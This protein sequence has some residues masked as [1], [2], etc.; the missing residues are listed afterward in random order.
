[1]RWLTFFAA[2]AFVAASLGAAPAYDFRIFPTNSFVQCVVDGKALESFPPVARLKESLDVQ[3]RKGLSGS[4]LAASSLRDSI[5][6]YALAFMPLDMVP[7]PKPKADGDDDDGDFEAV[8]FLGFSTNA[9]IK[10]LGEAVSDM[11]KS[12]SEED[13][14]RATY[15]VLGGDAIR[16][17]VTNETPGKTD[18]VDDECGSFCIALAGDTLAVAASDEKIARRV[19]D[20]VRCGR[21]MRPAI[22]ATRPFFWLTA[23]VDPIEIFGAAD[24]DEEDDEASMLDAM[25]FLKGMSRLV[26]AVEG[27]QKDESLRVSISATFASVQDAASAAAALKSL[28]GLASMAGNADGNPAASL[29]ARAKVDATGT[30][31]RVSAMFPCE[32]LKRLFD[33]DSH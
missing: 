24:D 14:V 23:N 9:T 8:V 30:E 15:E 25:P 29:A 26:A 16:V 22:P 17:N 10:T 13:G 27:V 32:E 3:K 6:Y 5:D 28:I 12:Q 18:A 7:A 11:A 31:C 20:D 1:M 19:A 21:A 33:A 4:A 2:T